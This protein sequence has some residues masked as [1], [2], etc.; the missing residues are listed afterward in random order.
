MINK[1]TTLF[2]LITFS[3]NLVA[4]EKIIFPLPK[5]KVLTEET[6]DETINVVYAPERP[7]TDEIEE[8]VL[9]KTLIAK[10][11]SDAQTWLEKLRA[12]RKTEC[13]HFSFIE[14][15]VQGADPS[16]ASGQ[17][18]YCGQEKSSG[19]GVISMQ[20]VTQGH[21]NLYV[22]E[23]RWTTYPFDHPE[24]AFVVREELMPWIRQMTRAYVCGPDAVPCGK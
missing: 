18:L 2:F 22:I 15:P 8:S 23:K 10:T 17:V 6:N 5:W 20:R 11:G 21:E 13:D 14:I 1:I 4:Q 24:N 7:L 16:P 9:I 19:N 3:S 12:D